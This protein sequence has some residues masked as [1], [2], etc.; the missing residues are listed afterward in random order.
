MKSVCAWCGKHLH[1]VEA[2]EDVSH[3]ICMVCAETLLHPDELPRRFFTRYLVQ[4]DGGAGWSYVQAYET[5]AAAE[6]ARAL[7]AQHVTD[8]RFLRVVRK[9]FER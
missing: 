8:P 4:F 6:D 2:D 1:G 9:D 5:A 7:M 3:G